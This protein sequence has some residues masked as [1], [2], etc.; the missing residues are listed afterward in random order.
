M[1]DRIL[2][3][4][5]DIQTLFGSPGEAFAA[6]DQLRD[7]AAAAHAELLRQAFS[8]YD[9]NP[10]LKVILDFLD[11]PA[12]ANDQQEL[13]CHPLLIEGLH[14]LSDG[15][16]ALRAWHAAVAPK[17][18]HSGPDPSGPAA[19]ARLGA[20]ALVLLLRNH[21]DWQGGLDL[22]TDGFGRLCFPFC[23]WS[24]QVRDAAGDPLGN[25]AVNI[26]ID[27]REARWRL[28]GDS[29]S[30]FLIMQ[31]EDLISAVAR[32]DEDL[33]LSRLRFPDAR[34]RIRLQ[35]A[36][37]FSDSPIRYDPV[38]FHDFKAHAGTTGGLID[39]LLT[40]TRHNSPAIDRELSAFIHSVRGFELPDSPQA[41]GAI[42]S[43]SD[44]RL[45]GVMGVNI[46]YTLQHEPCLGQ[47]FF[48]N[49]GHEL[50]HS[51]N[52]LIDTVL[53]CA[54]EALVLNPADHT[55]LVPRYG[56]ALGVRT[57]FQIPYVHLYEWAL[58]MDFA[59]ANFRDL[60]WEVSEDWRE[61]GDDI[62]AEIA[63]AFDMIA[64]VARLTPLGEAAV[65]HFRKLFDAASERWR[66]VA[67]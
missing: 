29:E 49:L 37:T 2:S 66:E 35:F 39:H 58:L 55:A 15:C 44:P 62:E 18:P 4:E 31:R 27:N 25:R 60:P 45:P 54:G 13:L 14:A 51:K 8:A 64:R 48:T 42:E 52:Y 6:A 33:Q 19:Q 43:F 32:N 50:G 3:G 20:T 28:T 63:E 5:T 11:G 12:A 9:Q 40:A 67:R 1:T 23:D 46:G 16:P 59:Q 36:R 53:H 65:T 21:P 7:R 34:L 61:F 22:A 38:G 24:V 47:F 41:G 10:A 57:V 26:S 17:A 30:P 56:R